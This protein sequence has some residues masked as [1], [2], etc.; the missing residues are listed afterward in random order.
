VTETFYREYERQFHSYSKDIAVEIAALR[1]QGRR[2]VRAP[3]IP[4][5]SSSSGSIPVERDV[6]T[7]QGTVPARVV[8]RS[9]LVPGTSLRGPL[10]VTQEDSTTWVPPNWVADVNPIGNLV[11][12]QGG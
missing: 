8:R 6:M 12:I 7:R 5:R 11:L 4:F 9:S 1:V 3:H 10:V 2:P